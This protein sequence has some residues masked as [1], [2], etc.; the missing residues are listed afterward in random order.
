MTPARKALFSA[1]MLLLMATATLAGVEL[2]VRLVFPQPEFYPRYRY[3]ERYGHLL[4]PSA[5]IVNRLPGGWR[6]VYR[7][8]EYG[9]RVSMPEVSNRYELPNV[10]LLGDSYTFGF[11]VNDGEQYSAVLASRFAA[12]AGIVNLGVGSFGLTQEIR[13]FYEFGQLFQP[14]VVVVQFCSNDPDDNFFAK[15]TTVS[16]DGRFRFHR[17]RS[18]GSALSFARKWLSGSILQRSAAYNLIRNRAYRMWE[19]RAAASAGDREAKEA[20]YNELLTAFAD[21]LHER[22]IELLLFDVPGQ[23]ASWPGIKR[24]VEALDGAGRLRYLRTEQWFKGVTDYGSPEGHP[25]GAKGHRVIAERLEGPL[26]AAL[27][28]AAAAQTAP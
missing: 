28:L 12:Q 5:T 19:A 14:A 22:G 10:V 17:D 2:A 11:G 4:P 25:W 16:D 1:I 20:F 21:D 26:R 23:L 8:N 6:F 13:S 9:F 7:T 24:Q 18:T 27:Q 3:S 15:V